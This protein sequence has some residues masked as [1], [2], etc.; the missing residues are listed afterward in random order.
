[1]DVGWVRRVVQR[2]GEKKV[3]VLDGGVEDCGG[4][5]GRGGGFNGEWGGFDIGG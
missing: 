4:R 2:W 3:G 5:V 1:M